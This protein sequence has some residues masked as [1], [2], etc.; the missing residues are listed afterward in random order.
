MGVKV[1]CNR[2]RHFVEQNDTLP[3]DNVAITQI[4]NIAIDGEAFIL[5][6]FG[7]DGNDKYSYPSALCEYYRYLSVIF[8]EN[9]FDLETAELYSRKKLTNGFG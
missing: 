5:K 8:K 7:R 4:R 2:I 3:Y 6:Y 1:Y 9:D